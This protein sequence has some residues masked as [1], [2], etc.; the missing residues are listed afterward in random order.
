MGWGA[1]G[2]TTNQTGD[3]VGVQSRLSVPDA[4]FWNCTKHVISRWP[5]S[6]R[7][8]ARSALTKA[9]KARTLTDRVL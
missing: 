8:L 3:D 6:F 4:L 9:L 2:I 7:S 5:Q 1:G